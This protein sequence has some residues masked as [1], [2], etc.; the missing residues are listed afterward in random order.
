M[1][2]VFFKIIVYQFKV[3]NQLIISLKPVCYFANVKRSA[4]Y[5]I[6]LQ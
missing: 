1:S 6:R 3:R 4:I 5:A 2:P